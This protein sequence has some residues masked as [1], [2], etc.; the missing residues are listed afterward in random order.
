L[1]YLGP[2]AS[3]TADILGTWFESIL[4]GPRRYSSITMLRAYG[5]LADLLS[6]QRIVA[7]DTV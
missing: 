6:M 7:E 1:Q 3:P 5:V 4:S 2:N